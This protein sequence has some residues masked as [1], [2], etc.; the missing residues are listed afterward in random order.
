MG[1]E[2]MLACF[3]FYLVAALLLY[4]IGIAPLSLVIIPVLGLAL[5][6]MFGDLVIAVRRMRMA[7]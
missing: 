7:R 2:M 5:A 6:V 3:R 1:G 4:V